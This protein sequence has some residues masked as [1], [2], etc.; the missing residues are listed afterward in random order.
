MNTDPHI[1][2][3]EIA[4]IRPHPDNPRV[5]TKKQIRQIAESIKAFGFRMPVLIDQDTRLFCG[6]ARVEACKLIG[7][8]RVPA[9]RVTDLSDAQVRALMIADNR[10]TEISTWD[11]QLLGENLKVLS[12]TELDFDI[13]CIGFDYGEIEHRILDLEDHG[14]QDDESD[15][16]PDLGDVAPVTRPGDLWIL[17]EGESPHR[18]LCADCT[19]SESYKPLL[20]DRHAAMVFTDPPYNLS[21][22][23]IG[24]VCA[25]EHGDFEMA[26]GEM[27]PEQ[28]TA[29]LG[30]VMERLCSVSEH[31]SIHYL[32][33]DWRH[34]SEM[35]AAGNVHY[36]ELKNL[37]VWVKDRPGMGTFYR[38]QHELVFVFK[39]GDERHRNHFGLGEHGRTRS[40]VW[41]FPSVRSLDSAD[42]DPDGDALK[43]HPTIKPVRLI[44]EAIL[45]CSRRGE[46][47]LD[48]F[49]GSGSTLIA[50]EKAERVC[51]GIE[52]SP[53][54]VDVAIARWQQWTGN[55][56]VHEATGNT[57]AELAE[58]HAAEAGEVA[59]G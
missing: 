48:P 26:S 21:A 23:A 45:D 32:F 30:T 53:R 2:Q 41:C 7:M 3:I 27:S 35:L 25:G 6:H 12:D 46:I 37:C 15:N 17:G 57:H 50:C 43:L 1:E 56:A 54:Y 51:A 18:I 10:L 11:D 52:L 59:H 49:L 8:D 5:H 16:L 40:N 36:T 29:F 33:M 24:Q 22:K 47:V 14:E 19:D 42:G 13:E 55:N 4:S 28:F 20:G 34:A 9:L 58:I 44:E 31:G 38:S 39:H